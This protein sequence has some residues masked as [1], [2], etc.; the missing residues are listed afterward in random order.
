MNTDKP[1]SDSSGYRYDDPSPYGPSLIREALA[2]Y[3]GDTENDGGYTLDDYYALPDERRVELID[4]VFYDMA[5]PTSIH[6]Y[7]IT[8][9]WRI[10]SNYV[11][12]K[13]GTCITLVSPLDVQLDCDDRTMVQPDIVV[14]CDNKKLT[15]KVVFGAP[16]FTLEVFSPSTKKK[17]MFLKLTKYKEAGVR[18][19]WMVDPDKKQVIVYRFEDDDLMSLYSFN[20]RVPVGIFGGDCCVDFAEICGYAGFLGISGL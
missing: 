3:A 17:D 10:L 16:D 5:A 12:S 19:Y 2:E 15:E 7:L 13:K 14:I 1:D 4:G 6:Q 11:R 8:E 9:I 20:D 18:E